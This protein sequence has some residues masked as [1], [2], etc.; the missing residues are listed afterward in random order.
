MTAKKAIAGLDFLIRNK[1]EV[2]N[3][4]IIGK[5]KPCFKHYDRY[6]RIFEPKYNG[7]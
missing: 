7:R 6:V 3:G 1:Q 4:M 2:R 5:L